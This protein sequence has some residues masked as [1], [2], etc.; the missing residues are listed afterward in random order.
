[1]KGIRR[2]LGCF[3][4]AVF[5]LSGG[6]RDAGAAPDV[7]RFNVV[8]SAN[9]TQL[10]A[11]EINDFLNDYNTIVLRPRG[12][13]TMDKISNAWFHQTELRYFVRPN[14]A[15]SAGFGQIVSKA[16]Q[17]YLPRIAQSITHRIHVVAVPLHIGASYYLQPYTQ[18][19]FQ[20]RA[21]LGGGFVSVTQAKVVFERMEFTTD[22][23]TTL[24]Y[25]FGD[26]NA[27]KSVRFK[28]RGDAPGFYVEVGAHLWFATRYSVMIGG[29]YRSATVRNLEYVEDVIDN[30]TSATL[31]Q[32]AVNGTGVSGLPIPASDALDFGGLGVRMAL[33]IGF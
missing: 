14:V 10:Q 25:P 29:M 9:P 3:A 16:S 20:A 19:D 31:S 24:R 6:S 18:G 21:Y 33:A 30:T 13:E 11:G 26:R 23:A 27:Q 32:Q 22:S 2:V 5:A 8:I 15:V 4:L 28:G 17:E 7:R 12:L 1:M